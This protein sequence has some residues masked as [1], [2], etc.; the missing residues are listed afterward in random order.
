VAF[1]TPPPRATA[2][3]EPAPTP[4]PSPSPS[5]SPIPSA[6]VDPSASAESVIVSGTGNIAYLDSM[7][8]I[9]GYANSGA[10]YLS[11]KRYPRSISMSCHYATDSYNEWNVAGRRTFSAM[12]GIDDNAEDVFGAL[13]EFLFYDQDGHQLGKTYTVSVGHPQAV[14]LDLSSVV[15]LRITC[16]GRDSKTNSSRY[17]RATL[18]DAYVQ[19]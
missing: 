7:D 15:R 13:A 16:S 4:S 2:A 19:S 9:N 3:L 6:A 10:A 11:A 17:F 5:P 8:I 18:G 12:L 14:T 1:E